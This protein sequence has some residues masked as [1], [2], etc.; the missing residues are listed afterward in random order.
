MSIIT[1]LVLGLGLGWL[2]GFVT[3]SRYG[4]L[5]NLAVGVA[6]ML[7]GN[8]VAGRLFPVDPTGV[9]LPAAFVTTFVVAG[10]LIVGARLLTGY[11]LAPLREAWSRATVVLLP[12][13]LK[14]LLPKERG[15]SAQPATSL[16]S[17]QEHGMYAGRKVTYFDVFDPAAAGAPAAD[18]HHL[19][20]LEPGRILHTGH[21]ERDGMIV[22]NRA[23]SAGQA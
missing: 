10:L 21:F 14:L 6:G 9:N 18:L 8:F 22:L 20:D 13:K 16:R 17:L 19:A 11:V 2:A 3:I 15:V 12:E 23:A 5:R 1:L 4:M 7:V